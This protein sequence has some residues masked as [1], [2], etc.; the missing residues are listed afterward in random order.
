MP[1]DSSS[2]ITGME[3]DKTKERWTLV[4]DVGKGVIPVAGLELISFL[5]D[6]EQSVKEEAMRQRAK[7][8]GANLGQR[9]AKYLLGHQEEIPEE[10]R[11]FN[12][13]FPGT[14]WRYP[15]GH[16]SVPCLHWDG[17][18]WYLVFHW[19]AYDWYSRDR[20]LRPRK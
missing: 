12:L 2:I 6:D 1:K 15:G 7:E 8:M 10:W 11:K 14:V 5:K 9:Q 13:V 18:R 19:L 16:L 20:L 17:R 4:E 3:H